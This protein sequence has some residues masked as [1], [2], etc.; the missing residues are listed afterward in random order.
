MNEKVFSKFKARLILINL[1]KIFP[2]KPSE[3]EISF[4]VENYNKKT[5]ESCRNSYVAEKEHNFLT[6]KTVYSKFG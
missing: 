2:M 3:L 6:I 4:S 1:N 5:A